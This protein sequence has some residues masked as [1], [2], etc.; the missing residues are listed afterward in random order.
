M[1]TSRDHSARIIKKFEY[2]L[3]FNYKRS[4]S[5]LKL[6]LVLSAIH[7]GANP[8]PATATIRVM[9]DNRSNQDA[10]VSAK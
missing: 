7:Y 10:S 2:S 4:M 1:T 9:A 8:N 6:W 3:Y 5:E